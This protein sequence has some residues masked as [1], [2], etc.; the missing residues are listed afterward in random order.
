MVEGEENSQTLAW[1]KKRVVE[2]Q[3]KLGI[4]DKEP[5]GVGWY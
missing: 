1:V 2:Q 4:K 3:Q 5:V